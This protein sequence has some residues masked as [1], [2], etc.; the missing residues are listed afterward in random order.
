MP[1]HPDDRLYPHLELMR[2]DKN[3]NRRKQK[4]YSNRPDRGSRTAFGAALTKNVESLEQYARRIPVPAP[5]IQPHLVFRIPIASNAST[6]VMR[7]VLEDAGLIVVAID[8]DKAIVAFRDDTDLS[9]FKNA[10]SEYSSGPR[11]NPQTNR[12]YASTKWDSL[13]FIEPGQMSLYGYTDRI[14]LRLTKIIG[15]DG[16]SIESERQYVLDA[17]LWYRGS[18]SQAQAGLDEIR[19]VVGNAS[20]NQADRICDTFI[21]ETLCLCRLKVIGETLH[22]LLNLSIVAE[23]DLPPAPHF[24]SVAASRAT[25]RDFLSSPPPPEDGP[26]LCILDS[27]IASNHPLLKANV[28]HEEA[29]LTQSTTPADINGHGTM[30][31]GIGVYGSVRETYLKGDFSSPITLFSARVLNDQNEFDDEKLIMEQMRAAI[32]FFMEPPYNCRVFNLSLG[33]TRVLPSR[34][35]GRQTLW[36][37]QLDILARELKALIVISAGNNDKVFVNN[38]SEA[39]A[40]LMSYPSLLFEDNAALCDP[41]TAA[42]PITVGALAAEENP[43]LR[44]GSNEFDFTRAVA[45]SNQPSP[46]TR[47]GPGINGAIKPEFIANGGNALFD[48]FSSNRRIIRGDDAGLAVMS[49][50][51]DFTQRLFAYDVGTSYA[52]PQVARM[53][54]LLWRQ[55]KTEMGRDPH[56]NLVR[57]LLAT[58]AAIPQSAVNVITAG[59][60]DKADKAVIDVCGYGVPDEVLASQSGD[61]RVT[62]ITEDAI[63]MDTFFLFQIPIP[64]EFVQAPGE[65]RIIVGLAFDPPVRRRRE[66]YLGVRMMCYLIRGANSDQIEE[67]YRALTADEQKNKS[68]L[69][70]IADRFNCK[71]APGLRS[72][73]SS[74]L[75]RMEYKFNKSKYDYGDTYYLLVQSMREEWVPTTITQDFAVAVTLWADEP[76]LYN[77][78]RRRIQLQTRAR[79]RT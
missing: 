23:I 71:L 51:R 25:F 11:I 1:H 67:A 14:G 6:K 7:T 18:Q 38:P 76:L 61:R 13:E 45:K 44:H 5:G 54:A 37:E 75:Q 48:G 63:P 65:K 33:D 57:A 28:G 8:P 42:I 3:P 58:S 73:Q 60:A 35:G 30:V 55:L 40:V 43:A 31:G 49:L 12:E 50:E 46:F 56:P 22:R 24:D 68:S 66:E 2:V 27:G 10:I 59:K 26:R 17:E 41:A 47:I 34:N 16:G 20:V 72:V 19:A 9:Q 53:A 62:L 78:I 32:T 4:G 77:L 79:V 70:K 15:S 29:I 74:T 21:G 64:P 69:Q 36:A 52:A 39:E